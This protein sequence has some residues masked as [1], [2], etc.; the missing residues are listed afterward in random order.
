MESQMANRLSLISA[1]SKALR[2][3][4]PVPQTQNSPMTELF[5]MPKK[6]STTTPLDMYSSVGTLF[7]VVNRLAN[8]TS[9]VCWKLYRKTDGNSKTEDRVEVIDHPALKLLNKPNPFM[10]R[11]EFIEV[12]QQHIDLTGEAW[13]QVASSDFAAMP[14]QLWPLRPDRVSI[15]VDTTEFLTGYVYT[16]PDGMKIP[17]DKE[18]VIGLRMPDPLNLYRGVGP[19]SSILTDLDSSRLAAEWNRNFFKNSANP[20]GVIEVPDRLSDEHFQELMLRWREQHKGT[21][22]AHVASILEGGMKWVPYSINM[23]DLQFAELRQVSATQIL[24]AFG[25]PK[26]KL[27]DVTDVNRANAVASETMYARSLLKPRLERIK[28]ALNNDLLPLFGA[29]G[30]GVEFDYDSPEPDDRELEDASLVARANAA[31]TL[32]DAGYDPVAVLEVV[33]LPPMGHNKPV[34]LEQKNNLPNP[35]IPPTTTANG[36]PDDQVV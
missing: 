6:G 13:L 8:D 16:T 5:Q 28:Q 32:V 31:K 4:S 36:E 9:A 35:P 14:L 29:S 26:F 23:R 17:L 18:D 30:M 27:G 3:T 22:N 15:S 20:G 25:F 33:E 19:V 11:Q 10:T 34:Q 7:A 12:I 1:V 24:Q 21:Q 2:N